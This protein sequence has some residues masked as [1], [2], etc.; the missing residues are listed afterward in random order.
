MRNSRSWLATLLYASLLTLLAGLYPPAA[1][2]KVVSLNITNR[3][4]FVGGAAFGNVG[5]YERLLGT[6]TFEVDPA[7]ARNAGIFDLNKA[8]KN[9]TGKVTYTSQF[10]ILK[11]LDVTKVG[12]TQA[13]LS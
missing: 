5:A 8:P 1:V 9:S 13:E 4:P 3:A 6:A 12:L 2:S 7:D 11:P 10:M